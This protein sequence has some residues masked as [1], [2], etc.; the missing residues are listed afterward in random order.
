[1]KKILIVDDDD[2][3]LEA[4]SII[5]ESGGYE[6]L[7]AKRGDE[8]IEK[9]FSYLPDL[10]ILDLFLPGI[11]GKEIAKIIKNNKKTKTTPIIL[12]SAHATVKK[13]AKELI[14]DDFLPKPFTGASVLTKIKN[15]IDK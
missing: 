2:D 8:A 13:A 12:I 15:L 6:V 9:T 7:M 1:M 11:D 10:I 14:V 3:I 4:L 5:I